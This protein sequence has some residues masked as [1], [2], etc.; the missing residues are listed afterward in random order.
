MRQQLEMLIE[1]Y[2][3]S[4]FSVAYSILRN[5]EDA[6]YVVQDTFIKYMTAQIDYSNEDHL[7]AWLIKV[8]VNRSRDILKSFWH[9]NKVS[10]Y[11]IGDI[12]W[13][14]EETHLFDAVMK[15]PEKYRIVLHFFYY[16][17]MQAKEIA[18]ILNISESNVK[19]RLSRG[20]RL[21]KDSL[22]GGKE[23]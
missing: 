5:I 2:Q 19:T 1:K 8:A 23:Q 17:D 22:N 13:K 3:K 11:E 14:K 4:L 20:R 16:E 9:R 12:P 18:Q 21:L 10:L 6:N 15:L 7:K